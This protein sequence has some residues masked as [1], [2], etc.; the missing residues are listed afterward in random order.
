MAMYGRSAAS[1]INLLQRRINMVFFP[2]HH[3]PL[4]EAI[5]WLF[6]K[7]LIELRCYVVL[8]SSLLI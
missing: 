6:I 1:S 8:P 2:L 7:V 4:V 5:F 3:F